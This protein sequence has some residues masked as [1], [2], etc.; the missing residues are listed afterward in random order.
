M[1][2]CINLGIKAGKL[3]YDESHSRLKIAMAFT[4]TIVAL[5]LSIA[6]LS[7]IIIP[8]AIGTIVKPVL[9]GIETTQKFCYPKPR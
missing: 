5:I 4:I 6:G 1:H 8:R 7:L 9:D 2:C 3:A